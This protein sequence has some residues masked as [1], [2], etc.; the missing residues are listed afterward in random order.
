[1]TVTTKFGIDPMPF[2]REIALFQGPMRTLLAKRPNVREGLK[3]S[4]RGPHSGALG[5][6]LYSSPGYHR[7]SAQLGLE[8]SLRALSTDYIDVFLL[9]D[10]VGDLITGAPKLIDYLD[11][12]RRVGRI[13]CWGVTDQPSGLPRIMECLGRPAVVQFWDDIFEEPSGAEHMSAGAR[14]TYGAVARA[15][16]ILREF[17]AHSPGALDMWS[18][19]L[20]VDLA[21]ES[22]LPRM[23]LSAALRRNVAGPVVFST[24]RPERARVAAEAATQSAGLSDA[25]AATF[26]DLAATA[27]PASPERIRTP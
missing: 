21:E 11:E 14:I 26:K 5:R 20:G 27:R 25:E 13:G 17:L 19:R 4:F 3:D 9:H 2:A 16:P 10:P 7:R 22:N 23:L 24:T 8:R 15:L 1:V 18:E 12:Q 6:L